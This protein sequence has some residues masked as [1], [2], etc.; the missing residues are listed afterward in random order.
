MTLDKER[1]YHCVQR[2]VGSMQW[3]RRNKNGMYI[4]GH[5]REDVQVVEYRSEF[6]EWWKV[7][8][9]RMYSSDIKYSY[10]NDGKV[11]DE[12]SGFSVPPG[13]RLRL[14]IVANDESR[15]KSDKPVHLKKGECSS[16]IASDFLNRVRCG[17]CK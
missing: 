14:T 5:E 10:D 8:E 11:D 15:H 9:K 4:D 1:S 2:S 17:K 12:L 16:L 3:V 13:Q 6:I 7:Y